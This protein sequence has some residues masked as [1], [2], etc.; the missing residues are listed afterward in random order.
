MAKS[1]LQNCLLVRVNNSRTHTHTHAHTHI[2][3]NQCVFNR[4]FSFSFICIAACIS[5]SRNFRL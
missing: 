2:Y 5:F 3:T 1:N 4:P